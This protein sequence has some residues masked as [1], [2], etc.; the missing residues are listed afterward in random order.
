[1]TLDVHAFMLFPHTA[2]SHTHIQSLQLFFFFFNTS[3]SSH[4]FQFCPHKLHVL[5]HLVA[6]RVNCPRCLYQPLA[7]AFRQT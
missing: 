3:D 6:K 7:C 5:C 4:Q 1:M 2:K